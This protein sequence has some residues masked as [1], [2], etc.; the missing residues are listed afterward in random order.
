MLNAIPL[1][2]RKEAFKCK[3]GDDNNGVLRNRY[4]Y[5]CLGKEDS[6]APRTKDENAA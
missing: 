4:Q 5:H 1:D 3:F 6:L 2:A